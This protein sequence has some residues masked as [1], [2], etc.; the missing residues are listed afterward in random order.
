MDF[1]F[2]LFLGVGIYDFY[3]YMPTNKNITEKVLFADRK[4]VDGYTLIH[5][6]KEFGELFDCNKVLS[7]F[8]KL[9]QKCIA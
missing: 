5:R 7:N 3:G 1:G 8:A 4:P 2:K 6:Q 9:R